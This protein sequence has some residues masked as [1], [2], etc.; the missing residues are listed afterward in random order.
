[1]GPISWLKVAELLRRFWYVVPLL[2]LAIALHVT[3]GTLSRV[4]GHLV[5]ANQS[6]S[7]LNERNR[8]TQLSLDGALGYIDKQNTTIQVQAIRLQKDETE[9]K[10]A[11]ARADAHYAGTAATIV[12]LDHSL[13]AGGDRC[14]VSPA[15]IKAIREDL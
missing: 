1:M 12:G 2:A 14:T 9:A 5:T 3:R 4:E 6:I 15:A 13:R 10:A 7:N 11:V 8:V